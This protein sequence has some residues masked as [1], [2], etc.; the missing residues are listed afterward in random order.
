M[1]GGT[2]YFGRLVCDR[3]DKTLKITITYHYKI[4]VLWQSKH[5][6]S[7]KYIPIVIL[8][9]QLADMYLKLLSKSEKL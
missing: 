6:R 3:K 4:W 1:P 5:R 9:T 7:E 8:F 2:V